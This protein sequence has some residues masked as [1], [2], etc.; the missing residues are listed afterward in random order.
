MHNP[1]VSAHVQYG[2]Q[3]A[4]HQPSVSVTWYMFVFVRGVLQQA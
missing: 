4:K 3:A 2:E 1:P